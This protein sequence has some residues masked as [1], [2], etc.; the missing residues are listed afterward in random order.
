MMYA[1]LLVGS[2]CKRQ[3]EYGIVQTLCSSLC[4]KQQDSPVTVGCLQIAFAQTICA[5]FNSE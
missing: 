4:Y 1:A 3:K 2:G 5:D